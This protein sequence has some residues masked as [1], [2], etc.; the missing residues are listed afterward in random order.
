VTWFKVDDQLHDHKKT[1][2]LGKDKAAAM[3][4]WVLCGSWSADNETDGFVPTEIV[5]RFD[6]NERL[7]G[8]LVEVGF[9]EP[10]E[11]DGEP[12]YQFHDWADHQPSTRPS[13]P[14]IPDDVRS[15]V[16]DRD[17]WACV[18]CKARQ[19]LSLDHIWPW[20]LGGTDTVDNLQTLCIPC[21]SSKGARV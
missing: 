17:G 2:R 6:H 11:Q 18:R 4:V 10:A 9:W 5:Q 1:R 13:R 12:G 16:Y 19:P 21:N 14:T 15:A 7:A 8:R 20:S 3:G